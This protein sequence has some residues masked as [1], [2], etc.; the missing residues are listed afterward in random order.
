MNI[1]QILFHNFATESRTRKPEND[2][3]FPEDF[4]GQLVHTATDC[5]LCGTC[6]YVCSPV[7]IEIE[8]EDEN[9]YWE[10]DG[11]KCTF[12]GR[13]VN[14]C[15]TGALSFLPKSA[16]VVRTRAE[17]KT[18]H[19]VEY[20][21]CTRCGAV[22]LPLSVNTLARMYHSTEAAKNA[23][24]M[25]QLCERCRNRVHSEAVK[26]GLTGPKS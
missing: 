24:G 26:T 18:S 23:L 1:L 3:P 21:H 10:Y 5:T 16:P 22:M 14:Y 9:G 12:C 8:H 2:V 25:H 15:P 20:Q 4:R 17:E 7:A 6:V 13:C 11:G 19:Y